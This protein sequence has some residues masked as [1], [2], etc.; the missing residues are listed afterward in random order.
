MF[1]LVIAYPV[2]SQADQD[3]IQAYRRE[4]DARYFSVVDPHFTLVFPLA[5]MPRDTFVA[6]AR[7]QA[8]GLRRFAFALR[9]ATISRDDSGSY[10][11]EFL[12]PDEGNSDLIRAHDRLYAG[13]F[14]PHLRFDLDFIPH[15]GI[16]NADTAKESKARIDALNRKGIDIRGSVEVLDVIAYDG[17]SIQPIERIDLA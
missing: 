10:F 2:L 9:A 1:H 7:R 17:T 14:A 11:H 13:G 3:W 15:I 5:D 4:N 12:V 16:G 6:E 8:R